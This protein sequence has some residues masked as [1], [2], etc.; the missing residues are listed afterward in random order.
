MNAVVEESPPLVKDNP[1][2]SSSLQRVLIVEDLEDTRNSLQQVLEMALGLEV[3]AAADGAEALAMLEQKPYSLLITDLRMPR[4]GGMKLIQEVQN[5][6]IPVT[7]M[8]T[9]GHGS[10]K[11]IVTGAAV[12]AVL[13]TGVAVA[14]KGGQI[15]LPAGQRLKV[16]LADAV[17]VK[18][19]PEKS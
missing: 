15:V 12:G 18:Y 11:G 1:D 6:K 14:T 5:R 19:E 10:T 7:I 4:L 17:K 9:T 8:V 2:P 3:D 13:G 16:R